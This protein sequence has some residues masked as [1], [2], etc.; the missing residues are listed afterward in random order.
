MLV[1]LWLGS[2]NPVTCSIMA[3]HGTQHKVTTPPHYYLEGKVTLI[4]VFIFIICYKIVDIVL[5]V[6]TNTC[7]I[8]LCMNQHVF[9][10]KK[11]DKILN[12]TITRLV[13][14]YINTVPLVLWH[15]INHIVKFVHLPSL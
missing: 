14:D 2:Y 5:F 11:I 12:M 3:A 7:F 8:I 13:N 4:V 15:N 6:L 9:F 1:V 10:I